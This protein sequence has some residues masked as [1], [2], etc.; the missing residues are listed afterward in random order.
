MVRAAV[1]IACLGL[2]TNLARADAV[3][4][5][6]YYTTFAGGDNVHSVHFNYNGI[7]T[8]ALSANTN[9]A[10]TP[11]ADGICFAPDGDLL[12]GGQ[13]NAIYKVNTTTHAFTGNTTATSAFN[14]M[15]DPSGTSVW[16]AGNSGDSPGS[17]SQSTV[18]A[19]LGNGVAHLTHDSV[20]GNQS[21]LNSLA[22]K[23]ATHVAFTS[24][25]AAGTGTF[26]TIN[27][28]TFVTTNLLT[29]L[30]A[31][32]GIAYDSFSNTYILCGQHH[33][34]QIDATTFAIVAD[35]NLATSYVFDQDSVDGNGHL[36]VCDNG[37]H[38]IFIDYDSASNPLHLINGPGSFLNDTFLA[39]NLDDIA[40]VSGFGSPTPAPA[41]VVLLGLGSLGLVGYNLLR[42]RAVKA[43]VVV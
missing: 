10:A 35:L 17:L 41:G 27:M 25:G 12:I 30:P 29:N 7:S 5:T 4:V 19:L 3:D 40:P 43:K 42:R 39:S 31:A 34:T 15:M 33:I 37:G 14:V 6:L 32:H 11:G 1:A 23:D 16:S 18:G 9:I 38:L 21:F 36:W 26:G 20:T 2:T 13:G 22:F 24:S 28:T 8:V